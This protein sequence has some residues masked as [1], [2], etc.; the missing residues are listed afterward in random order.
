M[1]LWLLSYTSLSRQIS[2]KLCY[3]CWF[4]L[5]R[6]LSPPYH[7]NFFSQVHQACDYLAIISMHILVHIYVTSWQHVAPLTAI[8]LHEIFFNLTSVTLISLVFFLPPFWLVLF[9][10]ILSSSSSDHGVFQVFICIAFLRLPS[11]STTNQLCWN[12]RIFV[13]LHFWRLEV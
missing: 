10:L 9:S 6:A 5:L 12:N 13:L 7:E 11:Q 8:V 4:Y 1:T 3:T 2:W